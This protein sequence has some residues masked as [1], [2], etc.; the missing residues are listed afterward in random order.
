MSAAHIRDLGAFGHALLQAIDGGYPGR[1]E[2]VDV[3]WA[4]KARHSAKQGFVE[5]SPRDAF[6]ALECLD[7]LGLVPVT[8]RDHVKSAY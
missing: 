6:A 3:L 8:G 2:M 7:E 5:V 4:E 1:Y